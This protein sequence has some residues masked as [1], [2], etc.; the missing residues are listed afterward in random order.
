LGQSGKNFVTCSRGFQLVP[1]FWGK[2][3]NILKVLLRSVHTS[4]LNPEAGIETPVASFSPFLSNPAPGGTRISL[5]Q[6]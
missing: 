5:W 2:P 4:F 3:E 6:R 1:N